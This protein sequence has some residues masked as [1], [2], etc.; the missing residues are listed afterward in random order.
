MMKLEFSS[1]GP[2]IKLNWID[3]QWAVNFGLIDERFAIQFAESRIQS[4]S[5]SEEEISLALQEFENESNITALLVTLASSNLPDTGFDS[6]RKWL[7]IA[8]SYLF[9]HRSAYSDVFSCIEEVY[10]DFDYPA[11]MDEF[12]P[13]MPPKD[14]YD[15]TSHSLEENRSRLLMKWENYL[16]QEKETLTSL[17]KQSS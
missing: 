7:F 10:A 16:N 4:G 5:Y 1:V 8:L 6:K 17:G 3:I 11:C 12:V 2:F 14:G 9:N 13:Y 15:P